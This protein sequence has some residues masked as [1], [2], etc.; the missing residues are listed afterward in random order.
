MQEYNLS[1]IWELIVQNWL[2]IFQKVENK[3]EEKVQNLS[4]ER[5]KTIVLTITLLKWWKYDFTI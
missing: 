4:F 2:A 5:K 1:Q 3:V